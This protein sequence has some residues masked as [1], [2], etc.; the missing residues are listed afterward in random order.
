MKGLCFLIL[1]NLLF[2]QVSLASRSRMYSLGQDPHRGSY[3]VEDDRNIFRNPADINLYKKYA[4][5]ELEFV[6]KGDTALSLVPQGGYFTEI[7][8]LPVGIYLGQGLA[9]GALIEEEAFNVTPTNYFLT[10]ADSNFATFF[11]GGEAGFDWGFD[12]K[13]ANTEKTIGASK[14]IYQALS[15]TLGLNIGDFQIYGKYGFKDKSTV[16]GSDIAENGTFSGSGHILGIIYKLK[17]TTL[18]IDLMG[19]T[20]DLSGRSVTDQNGEYKVERLT[21]GLGHIYEITKTERLN[22]N[23][24]YE[25]TKRN[26]SIKDENSTE[27]NL[28]LVLGM[29]VDATTWLIFR[30]SVIQNFIIGKEKIEAHGT[31]EEVP[32]PFNGPKVNMGATFNF[33]KLKVDGNLGM[34]NMSLL[35]LNAFFANAS[36]TY[37]Y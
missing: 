21:L 30:A 29:E 25:L 28:P 3:Y 17:H 20:T 19:G 16:T 24:N 9:E 13:I 32:S 18:V 26:N 23:L 4:T 7:G 34:D 10:S 15:T 33:G 35:N 8:E 27:T 11:I 2:S 1:L 31:T 14:A 36:I 12:I 37:W 6:P 5:M 22:F